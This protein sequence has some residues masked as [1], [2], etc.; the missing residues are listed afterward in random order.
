MGERA[1]RGRGAGRRPF[2]VPDVDGEGIY[3]P[4]SFYRWGEDRKHAL[5]AREFSGIS[6]HLTGRE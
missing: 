1:G 2:A 5:L 3:N 6:G 4:L